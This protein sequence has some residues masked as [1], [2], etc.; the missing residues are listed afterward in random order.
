MSSASKYSSERIRA[1]L[2]GEPNPRPAVNVRL[3]ATCRILTAANGD[4]DILTGRVDALVLS[5][6][7]LHLELAT[8]LSERDERQRRYEEELSE[9][10]R[11]ADARHEEQRLAILELQ[12]QQQREFANMR[13]EAQ[14][15][16]NDQLRLQ[17]EMMSMFAGQRER[18]QQPQQQQQPPPPPPQQHHHHQQ[19]PARR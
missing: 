3:T 18:A 9:L 1:D 15:R 19:P 10:R 8:A 6:Q 7:G 11:E 12:A 14:E 4:I 17:Q 16:H 5:N 2:R 13:R